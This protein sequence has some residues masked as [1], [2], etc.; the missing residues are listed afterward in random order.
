MN[1]DIAARMQMYGGSF[2]QAIADAWVCADPVNR[3]KLEDTFSELFNK[4]RGDEIE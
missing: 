2:A 4:Y 1:L 3:A